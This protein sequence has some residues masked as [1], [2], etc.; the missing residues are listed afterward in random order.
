M[1]LQACTCTLIMNTLKEP[2]S[3]QDFRTL[4][5]SGGAC[6]CLLQGNALSR[7]Q[8]CGHPHSA[9]FFCTGLHQFRNPNPSLRHW[10]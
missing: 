7:Y 8:A 9:S 1:L 3:L 10:A 2:R 6:Q 4:Q 5:L